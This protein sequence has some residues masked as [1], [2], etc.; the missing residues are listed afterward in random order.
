MTEQAIEET[1]WVEW[2]C[3]QCDKIAVEVLSG[4]HRKFDES[5]VCK[6]GFSTGKGYQLV[7][8]DRNVS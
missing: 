8:T 2:H 3:D 5:D 7:W 6:C 1:S 4:N